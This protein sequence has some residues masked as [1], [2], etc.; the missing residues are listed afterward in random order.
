MVCIVAHPPDAFQNT[1]VHLEMDSFKI[2]DIESV[3]FRISVPK[4]SLVWKIQFK[5]FISIYD[6]RNNKAGPKP[7]NPIVEYI[8]AFGTNTL[9]IIFWK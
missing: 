3:S 6:L 8:P 2:Q 1:Q 5:Y 9:P 7:T 4:I